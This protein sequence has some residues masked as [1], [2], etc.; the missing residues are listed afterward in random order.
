[1]S[2]PITRPKMLA[3]KSSARSEDAEVARTSAREN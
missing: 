1:L 3:G 2:A